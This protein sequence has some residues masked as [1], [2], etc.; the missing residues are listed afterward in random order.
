VIDVAGRPVGD[1]LSQG[2]APMLFAV[3]GLIGCSIAASDGRIGA[4]KDFL[5]D[6]QS[7][8]IRWM[9]VETGDWLPGRKVLIQPSA[10]APL[11]IPPKPLLPMMSP[12]DSL[13]VSV[14]LT[15]QQIEA[16]PEA[17]EDDPV[18]KDME[19][20]LYDYYGWDPDWRATN[21]GE[22]AIVDKAA[23]RRAEEIETGP[24]GDPHLRSAAS[25]NGYHVHAS[26]GELGHLE[27]LL[28]DDA[29]WDIRYLVI[30]TRNWWPG[31]IVQLA[32]YA[33]IDIDWLDRQ[34]KLN[35]SRDQVKS[36]PAW[37]PLS[38]VDEVSERQLH[39]HFGWPGYR[40]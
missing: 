12:G 37:D 15:R 6:D 13:E 31:K 9:I 39:R 8:K 16:S 32:R 36:A 30:A 29:H 24:Q 20:L 11:E 19:L 22:N 4:V 34:V 5:F 3:S 28:A 33:V 27:N 14:N 7:W 2:V 21:L 10:I 18:S 38:M 40:N 1:N 25:V 26:D 35:V 23:E 17:R